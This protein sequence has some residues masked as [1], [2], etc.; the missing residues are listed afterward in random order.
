MKPI[1]KWKP[2]NGYEGFYEVSSDGYVKS[3]TREVPHYLGGVKVIKEKILKPS[4]RN[5]YLAVTLWI[6]GKSKTFNIHRLV[7]ENHLV[8]HSFRPY[9]NHIDGNK[10]NNM[11]DN[12]EWV[13]ALENSTHALSNGLFTPI[14]VDDKKIIKIAHKNL[15]GELIKIFTSIRQAEKETKA[16]RTTISLVCKGLRKTSGGFKW[17]FI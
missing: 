16:S 6:E 11:I 7:A 2:I 14:K 9:V 3:L 8:N 12:L 15:K 10:T 4:K 13:T 1:K 5:G 17:E